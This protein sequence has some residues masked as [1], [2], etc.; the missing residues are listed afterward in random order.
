MIIGRLTPEALAPVPPE[1]LAVL[2]IKPG[3]GIGWQVVGDQVTL[4]RV[5]CDG[6]R[7]TVDYLGAFTEWADELDSVYDN[8]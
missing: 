6:D 1:V 8:L 4:V 5:P 3:D 7:D 2:K